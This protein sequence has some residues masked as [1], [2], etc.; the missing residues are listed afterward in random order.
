M[1]VRHLL[2]CSLWICTSNGP[3]VRNWGETT[4]RR[5]NNVLQA[6]AARG[7]SP[8]CDELRLLGLVVGV[9]WG[10]EAG[11]RDNGASA[12]TGWWSRSASVHQW[13]IVSSQGK[14]GARV[15]G[16]A[17]FIFNVMMQASWWGKLMR[18]MPNCIQISYRPP[19]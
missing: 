7:N 17:T 13:P 5:K 8:L 1:P 19:S 6:E 18:S 15:C 16:W 11:R 14:K 3:V 10:W 12:N 2:H 4:R 9:T